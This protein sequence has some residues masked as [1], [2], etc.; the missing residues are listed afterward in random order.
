[1]IIVRVI[2][3]D[4]LRPRKVEPKGYRLPDTL[5]ALRLLVANLMRPAAEEMA[6]STL[7]H[8]ESVVPGRQHKA[9]PAPAALH[10]NWWALSRLQHGV[11]ASVT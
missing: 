11:M 3:T 4:Q 9:F 7:L 2:Y 10:L 8:A 1:M 6:T 5:A